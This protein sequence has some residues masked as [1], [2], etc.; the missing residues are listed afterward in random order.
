MTRAVHLGAAILATVALAGCETTG[1]RPQLQASAIVSVAKRDIGKGNH[2]PQK[3]PWCAAQMRI[4][5]RAAGYSPM[6]S[7][8]ASDWARWGRP[9]HPAPG[10]V[11]VMAHHIGVVTAVHGD[12]VTLLSG[13]HNHRV[14]FGVYGLR[15]AIAFR[16]PE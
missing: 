5:T 16:A 3:G 13:N 12:S 9:T 4:W 14:G 8:K 1:A 6:P 11:M 10:A 7:D 15:R 2:T